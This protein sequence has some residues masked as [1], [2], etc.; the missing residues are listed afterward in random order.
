MVPWHH[1]T[2]WGTLKHTSLFPQTIEPIPSGST[3]LFIGSNDQAL[4]CWLHGSIRPSPLLWNKNFF[5]WSFYSRQLS[6][7]EDFL[8]NYVF[9]QENLLWLIY[10]SKF[11]YDLRLMCFWAS[12]ILCTARATIQLPLALLASSWLPY[13]KII[14]EGISIFMQR[15]VEY[16]T[17][18]KVFN[19]LLPIMVLYG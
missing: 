11:L 13:T 8:I 16:T 19:V 14:L 15:Y 7:E 6:V 5:I 2:I 9:P 3:V 4:T 12:S 10:G 18:S 17:T 1:L